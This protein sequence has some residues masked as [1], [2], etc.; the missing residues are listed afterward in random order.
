MY[1]EY[2][3]YSCIQKH[4][5]AYYWSKFNTMAEPKTPSKAPKEWQEQEKNKAPKII[6]DNSKAHTEL[7]KAADLEKKEH[8]KKPKWTFNALGTTS[9]G[10]EKMSTTSTWATLTSPSGET[11]MTAGYTIINERPDSNMR[12][13]QKN[14]IGITVQTTPWEVVGGIKKLGN[15]IKNIFRKKK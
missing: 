5:M 11:R 7:V 4:T 13:T 14:T 6:K 1:T 8:E 10:D 12:E 15:G 9:N 2:V 3:W